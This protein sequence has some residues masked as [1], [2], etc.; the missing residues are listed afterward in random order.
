MGRAAD[1][2][3][4]Q[5]GLRLVHHVTYS[6]R[7]YR[8]QLRRE[9][10]EARRLSG[11]G[12]DTPGRGGSGTST[13]EA[14][15]LRAEYLETVEQDLNGDITAVENAVETLVQRVKRG[16]GQHDPPSTDERRCR[17]AQYGKNAE[18]WS[19]DLQCKELPGKLELCPRHYMAWY[20]Y[21][22]ANG[23]DSRDQFEPGR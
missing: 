12:T 10:S 4:E 16:F 9:L 11:A 23:I 20:R 1:Y 22:Q 13:V 21:R 2:R 19:D 5:V 17:D 8:D 7:E 14:T 3:T 6:V 15:I 18:E